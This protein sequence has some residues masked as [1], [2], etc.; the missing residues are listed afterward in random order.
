M[1]KLLSDCGSFF[2]HRVNKQGSATII[3]KKGL[4]YYISL[5]FI[6]RVYSFRRFLFVSSFVLNPHSEFMTK[7]WLK[8]RSSVYLR[9]SLSESI[10]IWTIGICIMTPH[11]RVPALGLDSW[12]SKSR[13]RLKSST[14]FWLKFL[15]WHIH[16]KPFIFRP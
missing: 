9:N 2:N 4:V 15:K 10:H 13:A 8:V 14:K 3:F 6:P 16:Q 12:R 11:P 5:A 1:R 7:L